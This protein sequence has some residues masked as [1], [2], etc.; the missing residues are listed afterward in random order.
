MH[1]KEIAQT[2]N[3]KLCH[4]FT[5]RI[6]KRYFTSLKLTFGIL[7]NT[8]DSIIFK[9]NEFDPFLKRIITGD[10]KWIT[11]KLRF[12]QEKLNFGNLHKNYKYILKI[13]N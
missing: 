11:P 2:M 12:P 1:R 5:M 13:K 3:K 7:V 10:E 6:N 9:R 8:S 4:H